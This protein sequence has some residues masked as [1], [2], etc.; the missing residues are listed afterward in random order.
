MNAGFSQALRCLNNIGC[1]PTVTHWQ[2]I[3][4]S[5]IAKIAL[6][7]TKRTDIDKPVQKNPVSKMPVAQFSGCFKNGINLA[8]LRKAQ[9]KNNFSLIKDIFLISLF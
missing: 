5:I 2:C 7:A 9:K 8:F 3:G 1:L 4:T 6:V